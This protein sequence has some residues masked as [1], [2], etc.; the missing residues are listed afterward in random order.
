MRLPD[1]D[2]GTAS[3]IEV[4]GS[5]MKREGDATGE[6]ANQTV[7]RSNGPLTFPIS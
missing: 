1:P 5:W 4:G 2:I 7:L 6:S 3:T